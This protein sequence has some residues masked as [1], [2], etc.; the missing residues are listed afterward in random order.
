M[1]L[2]L[3]L[4]TSILSVQGCAVAAHAA[5][6]IGA[7]QA[8]YH[9]KAAA[10]ARSLPHPRW[11]PWTLLAS[12]L[13]C[14]RYG[15]AFKDLYVLPMCAAVWSV[16]AAQVLDFPVQMLVR[17]WVNHHLL[18]L[19]QRPLWRVVKGRSESYVRRALESIPDVRT[20]TA[21]TAVTG[22][23]D[24]AGMTPHSPRASFAAAGSVFLDVGALGACMI[25]A[26]A[27][28]VTWHR[29][30][31]TASSIACSADIS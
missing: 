13:S 31:V 23:V 5:A 2:A 16:P 4:R 18:D 27:R 21:V 7:W 1:R 14:F 10:L 24:A 22:A 12:Q 17:F 6:L 9:L 20:C 8:H 11:R 25:Y 26:A 3:E 28:A 29:P 19:L 30:F 15:Q